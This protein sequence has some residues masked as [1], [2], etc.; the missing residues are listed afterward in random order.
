MISAFICTIRL[1]YTVT[2][3]NNTLF[4]SFQYSVWNVLW[5]GWNAF[6]ICFYFNV[7]ILDR[8]SINFQRIV[9]EHLAAVDN[10]FEN[11]VALIS[12]EL[13]W[14]R[15][16]TGSETKSWNIYENVEL[17]EVFWKCLWKI[18]DGSSS[19]VCISPRVMQ[20]CFLILFPDV[21]IKTP[22]GTFHVF[23]WHKQIFTRWQTHFNVENVEVL[24]TKPKLQCF[25]S[26]VSLNLWFT[27]IVNFIAINRKRNE[28]EK[29][30]VHAMIFINWGESQLDSLI[31]VAV[32]MNSSVPKSRKNLINKNSW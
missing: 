2:M 27:A 7:G 32:R 6:L 31:Q 22:S 3:S 8:V 9:S 15:L 20:L 14:C 10:R 4:A 16:E 12:G 26:S 1:Q 21:S 18:R 23:R 11:S 28:N 5:L 25:L 29:L 24:I 13:F 19:R 30:R 17:F